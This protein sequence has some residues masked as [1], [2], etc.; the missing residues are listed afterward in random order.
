MGGYERQADYGIITALRDELAALR[1]ALTGVEEVQLGTSDI[2]Y[3]Y[4]GRLSC[5]DGSEVTVVCACSSEMGQ[6]PALNVT[7]DLIAAWKPRHVFLVGIAGG[8]PDRGTSYGDVVV[9]LRVHYYE[10]GKLIP[11]SV[12]PDGAQ[13][14]RTTRWRTF[15]TSARL[16]S[17]VEALAVEDA[18]WLRRVSVPRPDGGEQKPQILRDELA[19]GEEVWASLESPITQE[20]L[21]RSDKILAVENEASGFLSAVLESPH[22]PDALVIKALSDLVAGKDDRW[23]A[24]AASAS[25]AF[26]M[27]VIEKL[28]ARWLLG[29]AEPVARSPGPAPHPVTSELEF[30]FFR[31]GEDDDPELLDGTLACLAQ[32]FRKDEALQT[33]PEHAKSWLRDSYLAA[34]FGDPLVHPWREIIGGAHVGRTVVG[35]VWLSVYLKRR[36]C[37]AGYFGLLDDQ[38]KPGRDLRFMKRV[39]EEL[40]HSAPDVKGIIFEVDPFDMNLLSQA[41]CRKKVKGEM[42]EDR[43]CEHRQSLAKALYFQQHGAWML[44]RGDES[45]LSYTQPSL[46]REYSVDDERLQ[47][48]M[49]LPL[50]WGTSPHDIPLGEVLDFVYDMLWADCFGEENELKVTGFIERVHEL[51]EQLQQS[52]GAGWKYGRVRKPPEVEELDRILRAEGLSTG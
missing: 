21:S 25:A 27:A 11:N 24:F 33:D 2:R 29:G 19:S 8:F 48:L 38:R 45:P 51:K 3:Y 50:P 13:R 5:R 43:V 35:A 42:D 47:Y 10:P 36:W 4:R 14:G 40:L 28:G 26:A 22:P 9:P 49:L 23:R 6:Q 32:L 1:A 17:A 44:M 31:G 41:A 30:A 39:L 34:Q 46:N 7:R 52:A 12:G 15:T 16:S 37:F 20:V 18:D